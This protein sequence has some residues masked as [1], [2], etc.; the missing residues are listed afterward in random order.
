MRPMRHRLL[1]VYLDVEAQLHRIPS[2][3]LLIVGEPQ[4]TRRANPPRGWGW[5]CRAVP[6]NLCIVDVDPNRNSTTSPSVTSL[7]IRIFKV[8]FRPNPKLQCRYILQSGRS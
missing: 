7:D 2:D 4:T 3:G 1:V 8:T 5:P 6:I